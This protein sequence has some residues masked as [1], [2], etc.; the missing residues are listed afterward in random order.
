MGQLGMRV[1]AA[2]FSVSTRTMVSVAACSLYEAM[3]VLFTTTLIQGA[4]LRRDWKQSN[5]QQNSGYSPE[6]YMYGSLSCTVRTYFCTAAST[7]LPRVL[8]VGGHASAPKIKV[9][10]ELVKFRRLRQLQHWTEYRGG[11]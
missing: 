8:D 10:P 3:S 11:N 4:S 6:V 7:A 5:L 1:P 9:N 2:C